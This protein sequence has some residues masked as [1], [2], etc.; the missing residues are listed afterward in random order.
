MTTT[1]TMKV[2]LDGIT[3]Q[4]ED[5]E[6]SLNF[7]RRIPGTVLERHRLGE[8]ALLR[9]GQARLGL[10]AFGAPSFNLEISADDVDQLHLQLRDAGMN[11]AG[12]PKDRHWG[13]RTFD[14]IDPDGNRIEFA[15]G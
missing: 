3:L 7:Y 1:D 13:E 5:V 15:G 6:R 9:I 11:P 2:W 12:P 10:L 4:V 8:F 14:V